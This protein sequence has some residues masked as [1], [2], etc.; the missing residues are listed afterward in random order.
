MMSAGQGPVPGTAFVRVLLRP[1]RVHV[2]T[3]WCSFTSL[4]AF[5]RTSS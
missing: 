5:E 3:A 4:S 2:T 1:Q